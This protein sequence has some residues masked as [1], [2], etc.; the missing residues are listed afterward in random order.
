MHVS[1][2]LPLLS[3]FLAE[4]IETFVDFL[5][6]ISVAIS[7]III[8]GISIYYEINYILWYN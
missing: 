2:Y 7:S 6:I 1:G 4:L 8:T 5:S 3:A